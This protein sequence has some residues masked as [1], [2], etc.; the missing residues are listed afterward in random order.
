MLRLKLYDIL[1]DLNNHKRSKFNAFQDAVSS[2]LDKALESY[3]YSLSVSEEYLSTRNEI[4]VLKKL[5]R[6]LK[7][8]RPV[9]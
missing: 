2:R 7:D 4:N 5:N 6:G 8:V 3:K 1:V 9:E